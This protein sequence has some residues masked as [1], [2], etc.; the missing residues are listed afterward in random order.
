MDDHKLGSTSRV[1]PGEVSLTPPLSSR[2]GSDSSD[3][4]EALMPRRS[5][6]AD[7]SA[8]SS[9]P[10]HPHSRYPSQPGPPRP[11]RQSRGSP[12]V[13]PPGVARR[14][15]L[16]RQFAANPGEEDVAEAGEPVQH[17]QA[18]EAGQPAEPRH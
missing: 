9:W 14:P 12:H 8:Y 4:G 16:L 10:H 7:G 17:R 3:P 18:G 2:R 6:E 13:A 1:G 11:R 5:A 15:L